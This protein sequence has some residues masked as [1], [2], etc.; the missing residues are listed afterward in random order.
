VTHELFGKDIF[1]IVI[2][3]DNLHAYRRL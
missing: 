1:V 2:S 3:A